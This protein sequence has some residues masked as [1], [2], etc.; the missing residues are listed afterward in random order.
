MLTLKIK[1]ALAAAPLF[2]AALMLRFF[3]QELGPGNRQN[4]PERFVHALGLR[5]AG[6]FGRW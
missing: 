4:A 5:F 2:L 6:D 3:L 1:L